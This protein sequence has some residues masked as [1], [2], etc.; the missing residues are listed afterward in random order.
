MNIDNILL[1]IFC[2]IRLIDGGGGSGLDHV[3]NNAASAN[4][5]LV[6]TMAGGIAA[7]DFN[8]DGRLDLFFTNGAELPGMRKTRPSF[9]NRLY[10]NDG[11]GHFTDMT[12]QAG[13]TGSGYD[14]GAAAGD[15]DNDGF[16]D[17]F[18]AGFDECHLY[19]NIG[20]KRFE[21]VTSQ[22]G[23]RNTRWSI[24]AGWFDYDRDGLLDLFVVNYVKWSPA[25]NP[26]CTDPSG[27]YIVYCNPE[28]FA[29]TANSLY[30]N[31]GGGRFEDVSVPSGIAKSIGKGMSLAIADYDRDGYPDVF[32]TNDI[33]PN[34]LFHNLKNGRF[35]EVAF[36]AGV[37]LP[38]NGSAISGMG[39]DFRDYDNDGRPD[40]VFTAL[41]GQTFPLF[42]N[43][44]S[45][46][47]QEVTGRSG[48][49]RL[50]SVLSGWGV[51]LG[52][53][54]NDG[55]KDLLTANSHVTDNIELFSGDRYK[56]P[57]RLFQNRHGTFADNSNEAGPAFQIPR[58]HRGLVVADFD[59]DGALDAVVSVLGEKPEFWRN[60][61]RAS[62]HW[63]ELKLIDSV[64][65]RDAIGAV[66]H[67]ANQ[68][69]EMTSAAGYASSSLAPVHFGLGETTIVPRIEITWPDG[70]VQTL[71]NVKADQRITVKR[72]KP[73]PAAPTR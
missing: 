3:L 47:F 33:L 8:N 1:I 56:L 20:G 28:K 63:L 29:G 16:P 4:K 57:N 40:I 36:E 59:N 35:E 22:L 5:Y 61:A 44:G 21:D 24:A 49:A 23:I 46:Q 69:N 51:A 71:S 34:F 55:W 53:F 50:T 67:L 2:W 31:L 43:L 32:V 19:R 42:K 25:L 39:A 54:D 12:E 72:E 37:A 52:D 18:V 41:Q 7:F 26:R 11:G 48:L 15:F 60:A 66:V 6:E 58:A 70:T 62:G 14:F 68:W 73:Q 27:K 38:D 45:G 10:R 64:G 17:L 65:N 30:R 9:F 13:V